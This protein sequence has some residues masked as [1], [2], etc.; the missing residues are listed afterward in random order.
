MRLS[1][2]E[3]WLSKAK[4]EL[5]VALAERAGFS[6]HMYYQWVIGRRKPTIES[7]AALVKVTEELATEFESAPSP[8]KMGEVNAVC[9]SCRYFL[10]QESQ[11]TPIDSEIPACV[12][13]K[14]PFRNRKRKVRIEE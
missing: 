12:F 1:A 13:K 7:S 6:Q 11:F 5:W 14:F 9:A 10:A 2:L 3:L 8:L 4:N